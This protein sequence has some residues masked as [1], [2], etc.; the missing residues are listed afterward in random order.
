MRRLRENGQKYWELNYK[1]GKKYG[2]WTIFDRD[3]FG[4]ITTI[5]TKWENGKEVEE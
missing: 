3:I 2:L 1:D 4:N 5:K